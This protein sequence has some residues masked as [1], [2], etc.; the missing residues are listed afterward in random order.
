[1]PRKLAEKYGVEIKSASFRPFLD[2]GAKLID[3]YQ[4]RYIYLIDKTCKITVPILPFSKI[5]EMGAGMY[6]GQNISL[7]QRKEKLTRAN[8]IRECDPQSSGDM[9]VGPTFALKLQSV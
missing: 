2:K 7:A 3:G 5:D 6:K 1:M 4:L 8:S 9:A